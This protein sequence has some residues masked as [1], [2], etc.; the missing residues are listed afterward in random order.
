MEM[1]SPIDFNTK[2]DHLGDKLRLGPD[3]GN[4]CHSQSNKWNFNTGYM[5][6]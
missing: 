5:N 3:I 4:L 2:I 1:L 6:V